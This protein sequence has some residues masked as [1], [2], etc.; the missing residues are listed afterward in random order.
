M[1]YA[2]YETGIRRLDEARAARQLKLR[3][4]GE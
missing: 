2:P 3:W 1:R 4:R